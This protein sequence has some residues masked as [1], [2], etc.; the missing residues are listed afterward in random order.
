MKKLLF[1]AMIALLALPGAVFA[2][3]TATQSVAPAS[4]QLT[5]QVNVKGASIFV[6]G[7]QLKG[8][9]ATVIV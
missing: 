1:V 6:D 2:Q 4:Y 3:R 9:V 5:I 7:G 8:N